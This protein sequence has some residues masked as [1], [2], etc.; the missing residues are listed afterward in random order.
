MT[1]RGIEILVKKTLAVSAVLL[2]IVGSSSFGTDSGTDIRW[3]PDSSLSS[4]DFH[5][6]VGDG[7]GELF[8]Y[9]V[10]DENEPIEKA[11]ILIKFANLFAV[12]DKEGFFEIE[13]VPSG[14][15]PVTASRVGHSED[16]V[17]YVRIYDGEKTEVKF[18]LCKGGS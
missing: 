3:P 2:L 6:F 13:G 14:I 7:R 17:P 16:I 1:P 10:N 4:A 8:G 5:R 18:R 15:F 11:L 9:V 12:A